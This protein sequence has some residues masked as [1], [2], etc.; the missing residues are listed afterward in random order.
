MRGLIAAIRAAASPMLWLEDATYAGQLLAG[1]RTPWLDATEY[2]AFRR[3]A[4]NLLRPDLNAVPLVGFLRAWVTARAD[5]REAMAARKRAV[6]PVRT[7]LADDGLRSQLM[8]TLSGLRAAFSA[9]PL[10]LRLPSPRALVCEAW[11][12]AFG[13]QA[14]VDVG[15]DEIDSCAVYVAEFLRSFGASEVDGLLLDESIGTEPA[16]A[17]ELGW[18]QP[19][20]NI[21][22]H[23]RWDLGLH[24]PDGSGYAGAATAMA[25]V[26]APR[27]IEA[28]LWIPALPPTV[29]DSPAPFTPA[30]GPA[31]YLEVPTD[32]VPEQVLVRLA[33]LRRA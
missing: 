27:P 28:G 22:T 1:G 29:W 8:Q 19:V 26:I 31:R 11:R 17:E 16:N 3:K 15:A 6:F 10:V 12:L 4:Q 9:S 33:E 23:Y 32:A 7:L 21:A 25:F 30:A 18:Y 13:R 24:L 5:V 14:E 20:I 2:V